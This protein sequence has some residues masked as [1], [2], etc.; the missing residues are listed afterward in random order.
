MH[1]PLDSTGRLLLDGQLVQVLMEGEQVRHY[2][3]HRL[4]TP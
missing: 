2:G 4:Q 3:A 1:R